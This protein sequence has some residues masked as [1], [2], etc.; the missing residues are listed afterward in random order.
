VR[1][2]R[3]KTG[4]E[5]DTE[6]DTIIVAIDHSNCSR[7]VIER[8]CK[9]K[10]PANSKFT[11]CSVVPDFSAVLA[12]DPSGSSAIPLREKRH[13]EAEQLISDATT[14]LSTALDNPVVE[15]KILTGNAKEQILSLATASHCSMIFLGSHSR[16]VLTRA[17]LGS[18]S[19][20]VATHADCTVEVVR[21]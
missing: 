8:I 12:L 7:A 11:L 20:A 2:V 16:G 14:K 15:T 10:W 1:I 6:A 18:V 19:E 3:D 4:S 13:H 17:I 9:Y 5:T 21:G